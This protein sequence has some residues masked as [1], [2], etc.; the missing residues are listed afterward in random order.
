M[1]AHFLSTCQH[2]FLSPSGS[3]R[4]EGK[5]KKPTVI[6]RKLMMKI[7]IPLPQR[8]HRRQ[9]M[10]PR[11]PPIIK[12]L[13]AQPVRETIHAERRLL[14]KA[15]AQ[16]PRVHQAAAPIAPAQAGDAHGKQPGASEQHLAV[17]PVLPHD[18]GVGV[19]VRNVRAADLPR[20]LLEQ[21]PA[22]VREEEAAQGVVGVLGRVGPA[23][24]R[25]VLAAPEADGA[26]DGAGTREGEEEAQRET[27]GVAAVRPQAVVAA[28]DAEAGEE[29]PEEGP[30]GG[31][32][33]QGRGADGVEAVGWDDE[34]EGGGDPV[35]VLVPVPQ[36]D[37][38]LADVRFSHRLRRRCC[39]HLGSVHQSKD[40]TFKKVTEIETARKNENGIKLDLYPC[41]VDATLRKHCGESCWEVL[42]SESRGGCTIIARVQRVC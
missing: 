30:D 10:I 42:G 17:V 8:N 12:R 31:C 39:R 3:K 41:R 36:R 26:L 23:V 19:E 27:P 4:P 22:E 40:A 5:K 2:V 7:M 18:D 9:K 37:G 20:V 34:D 32:A 24:V 21:H 29:V 13:L 33:V 16:D 35:D 11:R 14:H 38:L 28:R 1:R 25:A 6:A 15:R